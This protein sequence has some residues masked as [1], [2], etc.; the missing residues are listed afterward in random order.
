MFNGDL[1]GV[2]VE[3]KLYMRYM[4]SMQWSDWLHSSPGSQ[5]AKPILEPDVQG[6]KL[7]CEVAE[8]TVNLRVC[9]PAGPRFE[10]QLTTSWSDVFDHQLTA[11][12]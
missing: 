1:R 12:R 7:L 3:S 10:G 6:M 5:Y 11:S 9:W 2:K 8:R 4:G